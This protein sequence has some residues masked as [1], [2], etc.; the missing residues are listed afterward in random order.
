MI[1]NTTMITTEIRMNEFRSGCQNCRELIK[2][3]GEQ[4][5]VVVYSGKFHYI[6]SETPPLVKAYWRGYYF[7][8]RNL[9]NDVHYK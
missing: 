5:V 9:G 8:L 1:E 2:E 3:R 7:V 4:Y 6:N